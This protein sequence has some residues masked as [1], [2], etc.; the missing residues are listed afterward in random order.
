MGYVLSA[1]RESFI[2]YS[3][4][5]LWCHKF[6]NI[7]FAK[8]ILLTAPILKKSTTERSD[9]SYYSADSLWCHKFKNIIYVKKNPTDCANLKK[10]TTWRWKGLHCPKGVYT[11]FS[12]LL[13]TLSHLILTLI[14]YSWNYCSHFI[15]SNDVDQ[16]VTNLYH[17]ESVIFLRNS[18]KLCLFM[19]M[20]IFFNIPFIK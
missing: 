6:K 13:E 4:D 12:K 19:W 8:K 9:D 16:T 3:A 15:L 11:I 10:S 14:R 2:H 7:I 17:D 5:P 20:N 18:S 1:P